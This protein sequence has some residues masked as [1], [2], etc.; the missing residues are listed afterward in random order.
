MELHAHISQRLYWI[1]TISLALLIV[2]VSC[3]A[4]QCLKP[5]DAGDCNSFGSYADILDSFHHGNRGLDGDSDGAPC[6]NRLK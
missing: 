1:A 3:N 4:W 5:K 2:S 6:E